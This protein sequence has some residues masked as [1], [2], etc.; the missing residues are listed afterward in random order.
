M[1]WYIV[2]E[3]RQTEKKIYGAWLAHVFPGIEPVPRIEDIAEQR[4]Y[5]VYGNGYPSYID[6]IRAA[7][8]DIRANPGAFDHLMVYVDA[9]D[10]SVVERRT[11]IIAL[12]AESSWPIAHTVVVHDCCIET[13][14]LG[15]RKL[16]KENPESADLRRY[17]EFYDVRTHDPERLPNFDTARSRA[18]FH[19]LYL[20]E[21]FRACGDHMSY[22]KQQPRHACDR[23]Y[24]EQLV[25][26]V[27]S[28]RHLASFDYLL[29]R[30]RSLGGQI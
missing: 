4:Y 22:T 15:N 16:A 30:W 7:L 21:M 9:E 13:W 3:G 2:V 14:L 27:N 8:A 28:T 26:R 19:L 11:E 23:S 20:Q 29:Q 5:L 18:S 24:L 17:Y 25:S 10:V 12:I 1:K 6:R